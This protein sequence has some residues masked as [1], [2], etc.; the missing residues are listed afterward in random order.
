MV[1]QGVWLWS[2]KGFWLWLIKGFWLWFSKGFWLWLT[3]L[4]VQ[5][6][7]QK[8]VEDKTFGMKNKKV[9]RRRLVYVPVLHVLVFVA[10]MF[11][12][13]MFWWLSL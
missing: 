9:R 12:F 13:F 6:Q 7:K 1:E 11:L 8:V 4:S 2:I 5:K 10:L 3:V